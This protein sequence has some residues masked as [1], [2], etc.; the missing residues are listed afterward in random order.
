MADIGKFVFS[1]EL[2]RLLIRF[3]LARNE[4]SGLVSPGSG[5]ANQIS[6]FS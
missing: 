5:N 6:F 3:R 2:V 1:I 4:K